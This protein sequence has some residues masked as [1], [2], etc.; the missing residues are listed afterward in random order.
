MSFQ[1]A[2]IL[3]W[4][5]LPGMFI[6]AALATLHSKWKAKRIDRA[7]RMRVE[8]RAIQ[9]AEA[10]GEVVDERTWLDHLGR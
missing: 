6:I 9:E 2:N 1:E 3:Y 7:Y 8:S 5:M 10:K 4:T